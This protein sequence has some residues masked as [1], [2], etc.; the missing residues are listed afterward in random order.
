M[1]SPTCWR[2]AR[3]SPSW[4]SSATT[5]L[6]AFWRNSPETG[7][8]AHWWSSR[9]GRPRS[10]PRFVAGSQ[11]LLRIDEETTR[12]DLGRERGRGA[13]RSGKQPR[14]G[15]CRHSFGLRQRRS[16]AARL[17]GHHQ[18]RPGRKRAGAGR[19]KGA[20]YTRYDGA[21]AV[22]PN[23]REL[24]QATGRTARHDDEVEAAARALIARHHFRCADRDAQRTR[25]VGRAR[26]RRASRSGTCA[27]DFRRLR[28]RRYGD[29]HLG[30]C[31]CDRRRPERRG[32][33][34]ERGRRRRRR[35]AGHRNRQPGRA[36]PC[37]GAWRCN[38]ACSARRRR[39]TDRNLAPPRPESRV[40]QRLFRPAA[41]GPR[42]SAATSAR[43]GRQG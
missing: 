24:E 6:A 21:T 30:R 20:D 33:A 23:R 32:D 9:D 14:P 37:A 11:Q 13:A 18:A 8:R 27:R 43:H 29:G 36:D 31:G 1:W 26:A 34:C 41:S 4:R 16:D 42:A 19:P 22:T 25:P 2:W 17:P 35:E 10:K 38:Q 7:S 28:R 39:R 5:S 15:R 40:H 3:G 12:R